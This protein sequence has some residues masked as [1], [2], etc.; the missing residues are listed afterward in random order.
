MTAVPAQWKVV[1]LQEGPQV[2]ATPTDPNTTNHSR[3]DRDAVSAYHAARPGGPRVGPM[4][5]PDYRAFLDSKIL[6]NRPAGFE[7][8]DAD[9]NPTLFR[10]QRDIVRWSIRK[11]R[12][13]IFTS[14]GTGKTL[15]QL[16]CARLVAE[17]TGGRVL[18]LA[19]L[20]VVHQ[21][22]AEGARLG[23]AVTYARSREQIASSGVTI[24]NY[25]M[26]GHLDP[27]DFAG[28]VLDEASILKDFEGKTRSRLIEMFRDTPFRFVATATPS[29]NDVAELANY[30]EFLG[31]MTRTDMLASFFVHDDQGWRLKRHAR[32]PMS[33]WLASW[34]MCLKTP[35]DLGYD[36]TGYVLPP[37]VVRPVIVPTD[38]V[39]PGQLFATSL[40]GIG[41]RAAVRRQTIS[42]RVAAVARLIEAEPDEPWT[43]W[44]GLNTEQ[45]AVAAALGD[46]CVSIHGSLVPD[47][48]VSRAER[49]QRREVPYL[50]TKGTIYGHGV[51]WQ[52]C[53]RT[54]FVGLS[55]SFELYHQI[56]RR[57]WRFGQTRSVHAYIVLTEPEEAIYANVL[58]KEREFEA[59]TG[60]L[61]AQ[62]A[63]FEKAE[64][65]T[66]VRRESV[67]HGQPMRLPHWLGG[68][69]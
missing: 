64:L 66:G 59:V 48:K 28:V 42:D 44:C 63:E 52:H 5:G 43:I 24:C 4:S 31:V 37:L 51:N 35:A 55:D 1:E 60:E 16:E 30:A 8:S 62:V 53:A 32:Q 29:P 6:V 3:E 45:D 15:M 7:V 25:D 19:P 61:V 20:G 22:I 47:E 36:D 68:A 9:I 38:Y 54:A 57:H 23:I 40:K 41:D 2:L 46:R 33:R 17:R 56:L 39:P 12:A 11:G 67:S 18:I 10:F 27:D 58:R 50:V 65:S 34:G 26:V 21:T 69:S 49:W 14:T 13:G